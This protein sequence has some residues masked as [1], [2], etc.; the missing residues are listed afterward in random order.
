MYINVIF[1]NKNSKRI[2]TITGRVEA[3]DSTQK[4]VFRSIQV[5][6]NVIGKASM[7]QIFILKNH[8]NLHTTTS[9]IT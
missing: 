4:K 3:K 1:Q 5:T 6:N 9:Y 2:W 8:V 7:Q